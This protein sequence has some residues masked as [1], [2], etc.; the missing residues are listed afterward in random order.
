MQLIV[1]AGDSIFLRSGELGMFFF[2]LVQS[3]KKLRIINKKVTSGFDLHFSTS[4]SRL[5]R[6]AE[7]LFVS[8]SIINLYVLFLSFKTPVKCR[9]ARPV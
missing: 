7:T 5:D 2:S 6:R 1:V 9:R 4:L 8:F 3:H